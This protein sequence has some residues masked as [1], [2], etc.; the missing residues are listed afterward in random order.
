MDDYIIVT[1]R[2]KAPWRF[3][4]NALGQ[5]ECT[6]RHTYR[7]IF[8][9]AEGGKPIWI[10]RLLDGRYLVT[11]ERD[12]HAEAAVFTFGRYVFNG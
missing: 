5:Y 6:K 8:D 10:A 2:N 4:R 7:I 3:V 9:S 11:A 12:I 1:R